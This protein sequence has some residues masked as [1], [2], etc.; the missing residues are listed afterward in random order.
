MKTTIEKSHQP[1]KIIHSSP[2]QQMN[3]FVDN[4]IQMKKQNNLVKNIQFNSL[5]QCVKFNNSIFATGDRS[6]WGSKQKADVN[7]AIATGSTLLNDALSATADPI[8]LQ[9]IPL[10]KNVLD[11]TDLEIFKLTDPSFLAFSVPRG[12]H[13]ISL[14]INLHNGNIQE[15]AKTL[16]HECFHIACGGI[17]GP[18]EEWT[19]NKN[20]ADS[21]LEII[22]KASSDEINPDSFAQF[23]VM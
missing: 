7:V 18:T 3:G 1:V 21:L 10:V 6:P 11:D 19:C 2:S 13:Q 22:G 17:S 5:M 16:I 8:I 12:P 4:R 9:C 14:N 15:I 23:I 20:K